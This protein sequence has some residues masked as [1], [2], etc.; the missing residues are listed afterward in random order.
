VT[1]ARSGL[2]TD[3]DWY[4]SASF[5]EYRK[6]GGCDHQLTSIFQVSGHGAITSMCVHRAIGDRD[7]SPREV[8]LMRFFHAELGRLLRGPL[9]SGIERGPEVLSTRLRQ[10]LAYLLEGDSERDVA[11]RL[12]LSRATTHQYVTMLYRKFGVRSR[13][14]LLAYVFKRLGKG[15]WTDFP[16]H[17][18]S[19]EIE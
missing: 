15:R 3:R 11:A 13:S 17:N 16:A 19:E 1:Y 10:T 2:V 12:G 18:L 6:L 4:R 5:N 7:F 8:R 9:V 14:Q